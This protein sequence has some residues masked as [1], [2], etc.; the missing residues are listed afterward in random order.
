MKGNSSWQKMK[1]SRCTHWLPSRSLCWPWSHLTL[2]GILLP[3]ESWTIAFLQQ[4]EKRAILMQV[5]GSGLRK[6]RDGQ[7]LF[8]SA[9]LSLDS[10]LDYPLSKERMTRRRSRSVKDKGQEGWVDQ[11]MGSPCHTHEES[12]EAHGHEL[13]RMVSLCVCFPPTA[14]NYLV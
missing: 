8:Q 2:Q 4:K 3:P 13:V 5:Q 14:L 6:W 12:W 7:V 11:R 10:K 1:V 9:W